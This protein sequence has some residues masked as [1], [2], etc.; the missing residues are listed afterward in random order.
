MKKRKNTE[1]IL[2]VCNLITG[3][4]LQFEVFKSKIYNP[5]LIAPNVNKLRQ[6]IRK[7]HGLDEKV[8]V[9]SMVLSMFAGELAWELRGRSEPT[10]GAYGAVLLDS[11]FYILDQSYYRNSFVFIR[12]TYQSGQLRHIDIH[13]APIEQSYVAPVMEIY[14]EKLLENCTSRDAFELYMSQKPAEVFAR[15]SG[16]AV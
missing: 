15:L 9:D 16:A 6:T 12:Q 2:A 3:N 11:I 1:H 14:R 8:D 5:D 13:S 10:D 4:Y 7:L